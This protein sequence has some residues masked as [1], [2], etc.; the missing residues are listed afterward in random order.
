[1]LPTT[2]AGPNALVS[3]DGNLHKRR[4]Q[5]LIPPFH[6]QRMQ[7]YAQLICNATK[8]VMTQWKIDE[9]FH[10]QRSMQDISLQVILRAIFGINDK[11]RF[12]QLRQ[13]LNS[14]V[15]LMSGSLSSSILFFRTLQQDWGSW[16]L[17]GRFVRLRQQI[18]EIIYTEIKRRRD[19]PTLLG[20]DILSLMM[21]ARN[22]EDEPMTDVEL[23]D[24]LMILL[25]GGHETTAMSMAWALYWVHHLPKVYKKL[26]VEL[27]TLG[28]NPASNDIVRLPY[29]NAICKE[30]LRI[31]PTVIFTSYR[32]V[33]KPIEIMGYQFEPGTF[34]SPCVYLTHRR[35]D[36]I[37]R[38]ESV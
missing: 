25:V 7:A 3:L 37:L 11:A 18:D 10:V 2:F 17:W 27:N 33:Q 15:N 26:M 14:L 20:E 22:E 32:I 36:S 31:Y 24:E 4:K 28:D 16:S 6:G 19:D 5:M 13:L 35:K 38:A 1:M 29:L 9:P 30:T 12:Q 34:L 23:R 21:A 8:Q